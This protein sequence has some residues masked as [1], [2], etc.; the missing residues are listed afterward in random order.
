MRAGTCN[1]GGV[2]CLCE[3][4][5]R[6]CLFCALNQG[7]HEVVTNGACVCPTH[8][9]PQHCNTN[10]FS[11][12][13]L[14]HQLILHASTA[15]PT[16]SQRQHYNTNSFSTPTLQHQLILTANTATPTHA[17]RL[18]CNTLGV[19][20]CTNTTASLSMHSIVHTTLV[21]HC[22]AP[23]Q[24]VAALRPPPTHRRHISIV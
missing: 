14:Q 1:R 4:G 15:T 18:H 20:H 24:P 8:S 21:P 6:V 9:K 12:S 7:L 2:S 19:L 17:K 22:G 11:T 13:T 5:L 10:S 3:G 23:P 16:H